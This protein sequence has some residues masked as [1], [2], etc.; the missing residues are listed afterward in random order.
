MSKTKKIVDIELGGH[1]LDAHCEFTPRQAEVDDLE[2]KE[3][4][5]QGADLDIW[6]II[7]DVFG[8][9]VVVDMAYDR[10]VELLEEEA[11]DEEG[12]DK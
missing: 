10:L 5:V 6:D 4:R 2:V 3:L 12:G 11:A 9:E 1:T 8:D 7:V